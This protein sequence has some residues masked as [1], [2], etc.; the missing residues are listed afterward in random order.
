MRGIKASRILFVLV[1]LACATFG[2]DIPVTIA[3]ALGENAPKPAIN[4][5][6][7]ATL[8]QMGRTLLAEE[9]S[10]SARTL[11]VYIESSGQPLHI[12]HSMRVLVRRPNRLAADVTGDDGSTRLRY[13]GRTVSLLGVE[14]K[15]YA[16]IPVPD[17]IQEML[18]T[19]MGKFGIELPLADFLTNT[20]DKTFLAGMTSAREIDTV[21]IDG[22][23]CRHL[24]FTQS[25]NVDIELWL[26]KNDK[27]LPRRLVAVY[28]AELGQPTYFADLYDWDFSV[29]PSDADFS[30]Q[31]PEGATQ[32]EL[33]PVENVPRRRPGVQKP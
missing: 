5:Q 1:A 13:D 30:F 28:R 9:F 10:F 19:V 18:E 29:R 6:I 4:E 8:A 7:S 21:T 20:P 14:A 32:V 12:G 24:L 15:K 31:P 27:A 25:P 26:E 33:K 17:T 3:T 22:V 16:S 11:R 23:P 2:G